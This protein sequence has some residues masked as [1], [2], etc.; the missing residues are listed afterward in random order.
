MLRIAIPNKGALSETSVKLLK[1]AGYKVKRQSRELIVYDKKNDIE[2]VFLRPRDIAVYV[3]NGV[4]D[5]GIT[6]RDLTFDSKATAVELIELHFGGSS[7]MYAIPNEQD[8]LPD[9]FANKRI[10]TSYPN[11]VEA[12]L[13]NRGIKAEIIKLDGAVEIS[14]KLGVAD[15][16]ADV[17]ESG[18]TLTEAGLKVVGEPLMLSEAILIG[19]NDKTIEKPG[20]QKLIAR[21]EGLLVAREY[22]VIEYD[23]ARKDLDVAC[24]I[25]PGL[26]S[27]TISPLADENWVAVKALVKNSET[28][29]LMDKLKDIGAKGIMIS[30]INTCRL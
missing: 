22:A 24:K 12:D 17:V 1:E 10:A 5:L 28:N 19:H 16:I 6:G 3:A 30:S 27:P 9:D 25:T 29:I 11:I 18:R 4:L 7:F 14:I 13:K 15:V 23:I 21:L 8:L 26:E 2:F 20:V